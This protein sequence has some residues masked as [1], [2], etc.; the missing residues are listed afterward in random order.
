MS[1]TRALEYKGLPSLRLELAEFATTPGW[2]RTHGVR[3]SV[4]PVNPVHPVRVRE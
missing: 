3:A 1:N 4:D 2:R